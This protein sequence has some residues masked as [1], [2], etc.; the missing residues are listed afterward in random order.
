[1]KCQATTLKGTQCSFNAKDGLFCGRHTA[2]VSSKVT[3][4]V[5]LFFNPLEI[6]R[7]LKERDENLIGRISDY[8]FNKEYIQ[9]C[10][11][12]EFSFTFYNANKYQMMLVKNDEKKRCYLKNTTRHKNHTFV[13]YLEFKPATDVMKTQDPFYAVGSEDPNPPMFAIPHPMAIFK[14]SVLKLYEW[15]TGYVIREYEMSKN[16]NVNSF[17]YKY[18]IG[19]IRGKEIDRLTDIPITDAYMENLDWNECVFKKAYKKPL[20]SLVNDPAILPMAEIAS[21][22]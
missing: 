21:L 8:L 3:Q 13:S 7:V 1:M 11:R 10:I 20:S 17:K 6:L 14:K 18:L 15:E 9:K 19:V 22:F 5:K 4:K 2:V 12:N 16:G